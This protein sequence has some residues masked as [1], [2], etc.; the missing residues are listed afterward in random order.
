MMIPTLS[1]L[2]VLLGANAWAVREDLLAHRI[3]NRLTF[4]LLIL[5]LALQCQ[6][7]GWQGLGQALLGA[8]VGFAVLLPLYSARATGAGDVKLLSASGTLLG[9]WWALCA[10]GYALIAGGL[11][12]IVYVLFEAARAAL[13]PPAIAWS[14]RLYL[15][16]ERARQVRRERFPYALAIA[17]GVAAAALQ[18]GDLAIA[19]NWLAGATP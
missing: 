6:W 18:R 15:A 12:A 17:L 8:L 5:G 19:W 10:G 7:G 1:L 3:P 2:V 9:P 4:A 14:G 11:L 13:Q 16:R